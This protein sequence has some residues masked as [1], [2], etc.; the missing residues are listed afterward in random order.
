MSIRAKLFD[1]DGTLIDIE[2]SWLPAYRHAAADLAQWLG[3]PAR[4]D[5]VLHGTGL[6]PAT[7]RLIATEPLACAANDAIAQAWCV[8]AGR[9][10]DATRDRIV[11]AMEQAAAARPVAIAGVA[12]DLKR[13][14]ALG[15]A[16]GL[17]TMDATWV[18][19]RMLEALDLRPMFSFVAGYDAGHGV[20]P[21]PGM[22]HAFAAEQDLEV[23][24]IAVVGDTPHDLEMARNAG[25]GLVVGVLTGSGDRPTLAPLADHV[26][27]N[28]SELPALLG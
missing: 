5:E 25:A 11:V 16:L 14:A 2:A 26:L 24:E 1:K 8:I 22:V 28:L 21:E 9:E 27:E 15:L 10:D 23:A 7:G 20:K 4:A 12:E 6:D 13:L 3:R 18:A 17:A 19:D